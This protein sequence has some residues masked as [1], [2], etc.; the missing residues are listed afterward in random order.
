[1]LLSTQ[2]GKVK[3][4]GMKLFVALFFLI[5]CSW[6]GASVAGPSYCQYY[7]HW[8]NC[9]ISPQLKKLERF[10][11]K[12]Q[13]TADRYTVAFDWD[14][15]LYNEHVPVNENGKRVVRSG[16]SVWHLWGAEQLL[17][18]SHADIAF[19]FPSFKQY[20]SDGKTIDYQAW[21]DAIDAQDDYVEGQFQQLIET[22]K[23]ALQKTPLPQGIYD[24]FSQIATFEEGMTL[25]DLQRGVSRYL[26]DFPAKDNA[27]LK[28]MDIF[29]RLQKVGFHVWI[30]TGSNPY[31]VANVMNAGPASV[32]HIKGL[33]LMPHCQRLLAH[34]DGI[35]PQSFFQNC[36]IAGN[37]AQWEGG[38][39]RFARAYDARN[40]STL[41]KGYR[42]AVDHYGKWFAAQHVVQ[43]ER[44]PMVLYVGNSNG[45]YSLMKRVLA[46]AFNAPQ[47]TFGVF[48]QPAAGSDFHHL[49]QQN[50]QLQQCIVIDNPR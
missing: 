23:G 12:Y 16:Q 6:T 3:V 43:T 22:D 13:S 32:N 7:P 25:A 17:K 35:T 41:P 9:A 34:K 42:M 10:I 38:R 44:R 31:F 21:H 37:A 24:K 20:K 27:F 46:N 4:Q 45:D 28:V 5:L 39:S 50:C 2:T 26:Q 48:V 15:T 1:M 30:I 36:K 29:Q 8:K 33:H 19:L 49:L 11:Q 18:P 40:F 47:G 14:G